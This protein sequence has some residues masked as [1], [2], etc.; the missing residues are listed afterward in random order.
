[1]IKVWVRRWSECEWFE[2]FRVFYHNYKVTAISQYDEK[3]YFSEI[4]GK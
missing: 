1:M 2:E 3:C 4:Q